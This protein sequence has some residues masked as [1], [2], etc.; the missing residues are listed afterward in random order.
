MKTIKGKYKAVSEPI[1][2][3]ITWRAMPTPGLP[4]N[5]LD[6]FIFLNHHGPQQ[7]APGNH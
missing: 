3:L 1:A 7:Y 5:R 4:M 2:D 6:P